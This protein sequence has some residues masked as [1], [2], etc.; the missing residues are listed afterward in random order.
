[1]RTITW[2]IFLR[3]TAPASGSG[4]MCPPSIRSTRL[5]SA[6]TVEPNTRAVKNGGRRRP[7]GPARELAQ[8]RSLVAGLDDRRPHGSVVERV[9]AHGD[10]LRIDVD[11]DGVDARE[12]PHLGRD[13]VAAVRA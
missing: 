12:L 4:L 7:A 5:N 11:V 3:F 6:A 9:S 1:M 13:G 8:A 10:R 2:S